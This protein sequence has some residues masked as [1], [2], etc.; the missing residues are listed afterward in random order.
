MDAVWGMTG[1]VVGAVV[2][3]VAEWLRSSRD[4]KRQRDATKED[5]KKL[6]IRKETESIDSM[7]DDVVAFVSGVRFLYQLL[8][9]DNPQPFWSGF[10]ARL[11][12]AYLAVGKAS[13]G[14]RSLEGSDELLAA[15]DNLI[16]SLEAVTRSIEDS[17][18]NRVEPNFNQLVRDVRE[19]GA[20]VKAEARK[21]RHA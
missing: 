14:A 17:I 4:Y 1:L 21:L 20:T 15:T 13:I 9:R 12:V 18:A 6:D 7:I 10:A 5:A 2:G 16:N 11:E 19:R 8:D 3:F